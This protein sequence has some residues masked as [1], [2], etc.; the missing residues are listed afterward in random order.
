VIEPLPIPDE[1]Y[2]YR[3][4]PI[5]W[6]SGTGGRLHAGCFRYEGGDG[7]SVDWSAHS[8]PEQTRARQGA[9]RT[10]QFGIVR[11]PVGAVR[12]I[13]DLTVSHAPVEGNFAHSLVKGISTEDRLKTRQRAKLFA[14]C[15]EEW[16]IK[17]GT[18]AQAS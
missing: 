10:T 5:D 18:P 6:V 13:D 14:A 1:D 3:R 4:I 11:L 2:L 15:N 17:P 9:E 12:K 7:M 8:T 16:L